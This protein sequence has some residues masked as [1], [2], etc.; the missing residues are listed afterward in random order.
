MC[1]NN[2]NLI[3]QNNTNHFEPMSAV[4]TVVANNESEHQV[5]DKNT[6]FRNDFVKAMQDNFNAEYERLP[7]TVKENIQTFVSSAIENGLS[8]E[9]LIECL[10]YMPTK[11]AKQVLSQLP[12]ELSNGLYEPLAKIY[13]DDFIARCKKSKTGKPEL[14]GIASYKQAYK[15]NNNTRFFSYDETFEI[16]NYLNLPLDKLLFGKAEDFKDSYQSALKEIHSQMFN[17]NFRDF[18]YRFF[19]NWNERFILD[20]IDHQKELLDRHH[21]L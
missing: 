18:E 7:K 12:K 1:E 11:L 3:K 2:V 16:A 17:S 13:T 6:K 10:Q 8:N 9:E 5:A 20:A 4:E 15:K 19:K 14:K 21:K